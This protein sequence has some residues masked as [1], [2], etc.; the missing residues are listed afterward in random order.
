MIG[1]RIE[2]V[3]QA[4]QCLQG[5]PGGMTLSELAARL[6]LA[7]SSAH[8]LLAGLKAAGAVIQQPNRRFVLGPRAV[9][10][11]LSIVASLDPLPLADQDAAQLSERTSEDVLLAVRSGGEVMYAVKHAGTSPLK[12]DVRLG[13]A[14]PLHASSVGKLFAAYHED[15]GAQL[16]SGPGDLE[17]V[18]DRTITDR[19]E[20]AR[21]FDWIRENSFAVT[22]EESIPGVIGIAVPIFGADDALVLGLHVSLPAQRSTP[23]HLEMLVSEAIKAAAESTRRLGGSPPSYPARFAK[24]VLADVSFTDSRDVA[25]R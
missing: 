16:L 17:Q 25:L 18:T 5:E 14:R 15:L 19:K 22:R 21:D 12:V 3:F 6:D 7:P 23:P 9:G 24:Q 20:L 10:L 13:E 1:R 2:R 8:D 4:L 11:A